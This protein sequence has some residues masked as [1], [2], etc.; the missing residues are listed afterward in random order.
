MTPGCCRF[1][2]KEEGQMKICVITGTVGTVHLA[3]CVDS[4]IGQIGS[5]EVR[6]LVVV[7]GEQYLDNV[8]E[9]LAGTFST[10]LDLLVLPRNT[11]A[12]GFYAHR[13]HAAFSFLT[14]ADYVIFLDEDNWFEETHINLLMTAVHNTGSDWGFSLRKIV[15]LEEGIL[16]CLDNCESLGSLCHTCISHSDILIDTSCF[17]IRTDVAVAVVPLL[18]SNVRG[19]D[20]RLAQVLLTKF[21]RHA[22]V[23]KH[24]VN[25]R[26]DSNDS[27]VSRKFF[28][29]GNK[30]IGVDFT[31]P[32]LYIFHFNSRATEQLLAVRHIADRSYA[33]DEWMPT[34]LRDVDGDFALVNGFAFEGHIPSGATVFVTMCMPHELPMQTLAR[35]DVCRI[36]YSPESPNI[37]HQQQWDHVF[38]RAYFDHVMTYWEP[39]LALDPE[40]FSF[41]PC[42]CHY[43]DFE[44]SAA[45]LD[46][47]LLAD[48][49]S[50][51]GRDKGCCMVLERRDLS[52]KYVINGVELTCLDML[53]EKYMRRMSRATVYGIGWGDCELP[54]SVTVG[55]T[56]HRTQDPETS[57]DILKRYTFAMIIEN[58]DAD[59]F[60]SEKIYDAFIAGT[61]PIYY[62]NN[63]ARV[64]VPADMYID[65]KAFSGP[66]ELCAFVASMDADT[67][68]AMQRRIFD[69]RG[70]VLRRVSTRAFARQFSAACKV[71]RQQHQRHV[72]K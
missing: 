35:P 32:V 47:G 58:C 23:Q 3:R 10:R 69:G 50:L 26:V 66:D 31:K 22:A 54:P 45:K 39:L 14:D 33:L 53:R 5:D 20:R 9:V 59:G 64:A 36:G 16:L 24:T 63:N 17:L 62:G 55:H 6:H 8:K 29:E 56:L 38:L 28:E 25:Y 1:L 41:C 48:E 30:L 19:Q 61:I 60:V 71:A 27:S 44:G 67:I 12:G 7:D 46:A 21:P 11:G 68:S 43:L 57:V 40:H 49:A 4:V 13:I 15:S 70:E 52:G 42:N 72:R 65:A 51:A 34:M 37:R 18:H 2:P